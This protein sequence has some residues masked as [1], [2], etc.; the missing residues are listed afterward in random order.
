MKLNLTLVIYIYKKKKKN[1]KKGIN[2]QGKGDQHANRSAGGSLVES[3]DQIK[4]IKKYIK[5]L[6]NHKINM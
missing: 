4:K 6:R 1:L 5:N 2:A 3:Q